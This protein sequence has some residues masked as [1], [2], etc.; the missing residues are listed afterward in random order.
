MEMVPVYS[1][2][3]VHLMVKVEPAEI[4]WL[5]TGAVMTSKFAVW[6]I[7]TLTEAASA[8]RH[9]LTS[10]NCMMVMFTRRTGNT[11]L[12]RVTGFFL[13]DTE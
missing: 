8:N 12:K 6:A 3:G 1:D 4:C 13:K 11:A 5:S 9:D 2:D 7:T 10:E